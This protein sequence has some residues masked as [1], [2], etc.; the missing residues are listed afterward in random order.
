MKQFRELDV[1]ADDVLSG[2]ELRPFKDLDTDGD[3]ELTLAEFIAGRTAV[4]K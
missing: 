1:N 4:A 3:G 2:K